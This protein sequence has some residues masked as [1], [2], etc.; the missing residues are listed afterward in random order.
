M[1][2]RDGLNNADEDECEERR[3]EWWGSFIGQKVVRRLLGGTSNDDDLFA[4]GGQKAKENILNS[5]LTEGGGSGGWNGGGR[6][7]ESNHPVYQHESTSAE[8]V[9]KHTFFS[10]LSTAP[11]VFSV[12]PCLVRRFPRVSCIV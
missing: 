11:V 9:C 3:K 5:A 6:I 4:R 10:L 12:M 7:I 1:N 2:E 8:D